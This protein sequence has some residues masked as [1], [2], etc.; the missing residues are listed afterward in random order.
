MAIEVTINELAT[1]IEHGGFVLDVRENDEWAE[2][3]V[4]QAHHIPMNQVS[5]QLDK[6]DDGARIFVICRSG[7]R[8]MAVADYLA[9]AGFDVVSVAGGTLDWVASGR[10][11]SL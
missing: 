2:G 5:E 11:E 7:K 8:S 3:H 1:A 4:P 6:L 9:E 10:E